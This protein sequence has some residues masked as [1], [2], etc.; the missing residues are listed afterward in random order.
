M[1]L[2]N[3]ISRKICKSIFGCVLVSSSY[4]ISASYTQAAPLGFV[5]SLQDNTLG[6]DN[7]HCT[8][9]AITSPDDKFAYSSAYCDGAI[10]I[11]SR[12]K[13][14][15]KLTLL[16]SIVGN[17]STGEG[18][19]SIKWLVMHPNGKYVFAHG[20]TGLPASSTFP[21]HQAIYVYERDATTGLLS[22]KSELDSTLINDAWNMHI[23]ADGNF[24]YVGRQAGIEVLQISS[25]GILTHVQSLHKTSQLSNYAYTRSFLFNP[26]NKYLY[27]DSGN[28]SISWLLRNATTGSLTFAGELLSPGMIASTGSLRIKSLGRSND[29]KHLYAFIEPND[30]NTTV[31]RHFTIANDGSLTFVNEVVSTPASAG[32]KFYCPGEI[33]ISANDRL[34]Y[35]TDG[36]ADNLQV[37][38]RDTATGSLKYIGAE[39]DSVG[40][41]PQFAF[42]QE[43]NISF[44]NDGHYAIAAVNSGV[45]T[46]NLTADISIT[47]NFQPT[48]TTNSIYSGSITLTN[49][50]PADAHEIEINL[51][52][53]AISGLK[54]ANISS[55]L[56]VCSQTAGTLICKLPS[57]PN[58]AAETIELTLEAPSNLDPLEIEVTKTQAEIDA[59]TST[60]ALKIVVQPVAPQSSSSSAQSSSS[61]AAQSSAQSSNSS[62]QTSSAQA[63]SAQASVATQPASTSS[64]GGGGGSMSLAWLLLLSLLFFRQR[65]KGQNR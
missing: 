62:A 2:K 37:W 7:L 59:D 5:E 56:G 31:L 14:T 50:G 52:G 36:C 18:L 39:A 15:G 46:V 19:R 30:I 53:N 17:A 34:L 16:S 48:V 65:Y 6:L 1:S 40:G 63:S 20:I 8:H 13:A 22:F 61:T 42:S 38:L 23:S 33:L 9:A 57:L 29:G 35:F 32:E 28:N 10:N 47:S 54:T 12:D 25:N 24:L 49:A 11:F 41:V 60:D 51:T 21:Y 55:P 43:N 45:T 4:F 27:V 26:D 3:S 64:K 44:S 58:K